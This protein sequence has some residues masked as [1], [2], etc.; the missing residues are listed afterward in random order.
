[1]SV[2]VDVW[3]LD[4]GVDIV[5]LVV[6]KKVAVVQKQVQAE[7]EVEVVMAVKVQVVLVHVGVED[8]VVNVQHSQAQSTDH[9]VGMN[10][11]VHVVPLVGM[12]SQVLPPGW[13]LLEPKHLP[14]SVS[15]LET[16]R[17]L[18]LH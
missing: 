1:M 11:P 7:V 12:V 2:D 15:E 9:T 18:H 3:L 17:S 8:A 13:H 5:F 16:R 6:L 14:A 10:L 4:V